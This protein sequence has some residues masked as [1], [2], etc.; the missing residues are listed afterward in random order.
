M[1]QD[2]S[3]ESTL[4]NQLDARKSNWAEKANDEVKEKYTAGINAVINSGIYKKAINI[5]DIAPNF[6]LANATG[7]AIELNQLLKNGPIILT[8]YRGGWC[9]YCNLTL[10]YLQNSL[11]KFKALGATLLALTPEL[12]D[13]SLSTKEKH[14][15]DF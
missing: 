3:I 4:K 9:P 15:L 6:K 2:I 8:W 7:Q 5:G 1:S 12:P 13:K 11:P 10:K 14:E